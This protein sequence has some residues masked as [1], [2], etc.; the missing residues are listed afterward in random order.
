M[1]LIYLLVDKYRKDYL[2]SDYEIYIHSKQEN[3]H[4]GIQIKY[5]LSICINISRTKTLIPPPNSSSEL[6]QTCIFFPHRFIV[7]NER[8]VKFKW[9]SSQNRTS[10]IGNPILMIFSSVF[11]QGEAKFVFFELFFTSPLCEGLRQN[12]AP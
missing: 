4:Q 2:F 10:S 9:N 7:H 3:Q 6:N 12:P 5:P 11:D 1:I 8:N